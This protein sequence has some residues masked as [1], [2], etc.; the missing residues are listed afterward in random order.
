MPISWASLSLTTG[1]VGRAG[2]RVRQPEEQ[3][4]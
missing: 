4:D 1:C 2:D 3:C